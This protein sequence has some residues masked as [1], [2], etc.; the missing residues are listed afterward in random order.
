[1]GELDFIQIKKA[2]LLLCVE[3]DSGVFRVIY[4]E[5]KKKRFYNSG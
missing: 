3:P 4:E 1:M 5:L 2:D